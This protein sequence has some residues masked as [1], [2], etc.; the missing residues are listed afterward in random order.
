MLQTGLQTHQPIRT[1]ETVSSCQIIKVKVKVANEEHVVTLRRCN[2]IKENHVEVVQQK[3]SP[4]QD[5]LKRLSWRYR[6]KKSDTDLLRKRPRKYLIF[7]R[8]SLW[9]YGQKYSEQL[10]W[11]IIVGFMYFCIK[12]FQYDF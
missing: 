9:R 2:K 6:K 7:I 8:S 10:H 4:I 5:I 3:T 11:K 12:L 1:L